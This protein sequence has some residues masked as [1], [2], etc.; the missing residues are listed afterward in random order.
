MGKGCE[1]PWVVI[2]ME[3]KADVSPHQAEHTMNRQ[4]QPLRS[5]P[6]LSFPPSCSGY[7]QRRLV[8]AMEDLIT[9]YDGTVRTAI[10]SIVQFL[11]G[12]DGMDGVRIEGQGLDHLRLDVSLWRSVGCARWVWNAVRIKQS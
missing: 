5:P 8:K 1:D 7:I 11:Y 10:G 2:G 12:E 4:C 3:E 9:R 6:S